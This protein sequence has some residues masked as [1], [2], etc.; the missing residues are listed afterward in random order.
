MSELKKQRM[1]E[2]D[3]ETAN[4]EDIDYMTRVLEGKEKSWYRGPRSGKVM[5]DAEFDFDR[6]KKMIT[7]N[8]KVFRDPALHELAL[9]KLKH[10][11]TWLEIADEFTAPEDLQMAAK[12]ENA[13]AFVAIY[14]TRDPSPED[15]EMLKAHGHALIGSFYR[16]TD[17]ISTD[18]SNYVLHFFWQRS[19]WKRSPLGD[20]CDRQ[21]CF[22]NW[23]K[24]QEQFIPDDYDVNVD[25]VA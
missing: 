18:T 9:R 7:L 8:P 5:W 21:R 1:S 16:D 10:W 2:D 12:H 4:Q 17:Y 13:T 20:E 11:E 3:A 24:F 25:E 6:L 23:A 22:M 15:E 14:M 19:M